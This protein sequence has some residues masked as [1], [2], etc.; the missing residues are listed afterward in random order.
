MIFRFIRASVRDRLTKIIIVLFTYGIIRPRTPH[1][2]SSS[3]LLFNEF[4]IIVF[5]TCLASTATKT[6]ISSNDCRL[7]AYWRRYAMS[8][9]HSMEFS[10][11]AHWRRR[12]RRNNKY[13][14]GGIYAQPKAITSKLDT[15]IKLMSYLEYTAHTYNSNKIMS[16]SKSA[17]VPKVLKTKRKLRCEMGGGARRVDFISFAFC[18][19]IQ[20][21]DFALSYH[22][23]SSPISPIGSHL[24][25]FRK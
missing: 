19:K 9:E 13:H 24:E 16:S 12:R 8:H 21:P 2:L 7:L 17:S 15:K 23:M 20:L 3:C 5:S 14:S 6:N 18:S 10:N 4:F 25:C 22:D 1:P 11:K